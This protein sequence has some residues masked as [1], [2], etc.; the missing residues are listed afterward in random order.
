MA[1]VTETLVVTAIDAEAMIQKS[2]RELAFPTLA[3]S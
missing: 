1:V 2:Q 3:N